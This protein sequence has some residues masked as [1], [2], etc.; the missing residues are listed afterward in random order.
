MNHFGDNA[1]LGERAVLVVGVPTRDLDISEPVERVV[2][3]PVKE[4]SA[5]AYYNVPGFCCSQGT[6]HNLPVLDD[7]RVTECDLRASRFLDSSNAYATGN[8][9]A[10]IH[11]D[12]ISGPR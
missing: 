7:F 4:L 3:M 11:N 2:R 5:I 9:L 12:S 10:K 8:I 1:C 6:T